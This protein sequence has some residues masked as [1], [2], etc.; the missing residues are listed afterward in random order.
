M[1]E[2][3]DDISDKIFL[4]ELRKEFIDTVN[5]NI[6]K[7]TDFYNSGSYPEMRAIIHDF[8]GT[9]GVFGYDRGAEI[10]G[11]LLKSI[12]SNENKQK[13]ELCL[14]FINY[15]NKVVLKEKSEENG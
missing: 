8:K 5:K 9:G 10:A 7:L 15:L 2:I 4:K 3:I 11:K 6:S 12:D 1:N 13:S 14:L